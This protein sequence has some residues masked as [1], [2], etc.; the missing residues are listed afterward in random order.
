M[1]GRG[2]SLLASVPVAVVVVGGDPVVV[3][4]RRLVVLVV[5]IISYAGWPSDMTRRC[6]WAVL[7]L[8]SLRAFSM[9]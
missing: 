9:E 7:R 8:W 4:Y 6:C 2:I 5:G 1:P 3:G